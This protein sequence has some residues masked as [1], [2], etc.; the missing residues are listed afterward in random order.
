MKKEK[1]VMKKVSS[2][3]VFKEYVWKEEKISYEEAFF[4]NLV[5][6]ED[7]IYPVQIP[8]NFD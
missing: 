7:R 4:K 8:P 6:D 1:P 5:C 2:K 3:K